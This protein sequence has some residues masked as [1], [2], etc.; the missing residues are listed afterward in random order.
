MNQHQVVTQTWWHGSLVGWDTKMERVMH[1]TGNV[2]LVHIGTRQA[3][4]DVITSQALWMP[5]ASF[6]LHEIRVNSDLTLM[7]SLVEDK[8]EWP[9]HTRDMS[10]FAMTADALLYENL[11]ED[12]GSLSLLCDYTKISVVSIS[13][14]FL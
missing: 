5:D 4:I 12:I 1:K 13:Q 11:H 2:P 9:D 8:D 10:P 7:E 14:Y 3:A 6:N